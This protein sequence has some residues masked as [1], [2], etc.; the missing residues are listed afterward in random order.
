VVTLTEADVERLEPEQL[1]NDNIIEF[2]LKYLY[3]EALFPGKNQQREQ[4]YFFNTFFWPKLQSSKE[5]AQMIKLL[6]W[7]RNVD[8]FKKRF[9]FVPINDGYVTLSR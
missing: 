1:L 2:Y 3:E 9:L 6:S 8:I 7:T 4:F 5:E